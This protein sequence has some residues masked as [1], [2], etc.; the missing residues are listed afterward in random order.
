MH[1]G[2]PIQVE[3]DGAPPLE[4]GKPDLRDLDRHDRAR[5]REKI[6]IR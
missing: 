3:S 6:R 5:A 4:A 1:P 2:R